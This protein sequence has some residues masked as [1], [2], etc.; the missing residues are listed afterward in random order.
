MRRYAVRRSGRPTRGA[1]SWT[2]GAPV[3]SAEPGVT[4]R[5]PVGRYF[6]GAGEVPERYAGV[7]TRGDMPRPDRRFVDSQV[8]AGHSVDLDSR[9]DP[10]A[11]GGEPPPA[12][13]RRSSAAAS[14]RSGDRGGQ[15]E[16]WCRSGRGRAARR[17]RRQRVPTTAQPASLASRIPRPKGSAMEARTKTSVWASTCRGSS[18]W[19][20]KAMRSA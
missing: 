7:S 19:P 3:R 13:T 1:A 16:P 18:T 12:P 9:R 14:R 20:M 4:R 2:G 5:R 8:F 15:E 17:C 6:L 10:A 11:R